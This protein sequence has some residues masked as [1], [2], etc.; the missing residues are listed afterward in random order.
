MCV[1]ACEC[2][3]AFVCVCDRERETF[4]STE[5]SLALAEHTPHTIPHG[6]TLM[7]KLL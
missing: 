1:R 4:A 2:V 6:H 5:L 7:G 3:C